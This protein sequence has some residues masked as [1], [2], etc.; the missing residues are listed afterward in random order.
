MDLSGL[1]LFIDL[2]YSLVYEARL[3]YNENSNQIIVELANI[4]F[5][6]SPENENTSFYK[7]LLK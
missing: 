3:I 5:Q 6:I 1:F 2:S 4:T 7:I